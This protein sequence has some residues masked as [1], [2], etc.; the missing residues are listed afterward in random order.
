MKVKHIE[1]KLGYLQGRDCIHLDEVKFD[2]QLKLL[3]LS[4]AINTYD[5]NETDDGF[6]DYKITFRGIEEYK[7]TP[8]DEWTVHHRHCF[9]HSS[10]YEVGLDILTKVKKTMK[11]DITKR[12]VIQTYDF[13]FEIKCLDYDIHIEN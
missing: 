3:S 6:R 11:N 10:F 12:I 4:G 1:T 8:L 5:H 2:E 9:N 7:S 13:V